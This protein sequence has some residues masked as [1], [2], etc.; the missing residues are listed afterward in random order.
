MALFKKKTTLIHHITYMGIMAA[1]NLI[2]I[3]LATH[4][5]Y[6]MVF[7]VLLL[8]FASA[9]VSYYCQKIYYLVYACATI[10]LCLI[11]NPSDTLF[12]VVP[13]VISGF[14]IGLFLEL[15]INL[16][17]P[18]LTS[19]I[20]NTAFTFA[21]VPLIDLI[22]ETSLLNILQIK[23]YK[24]CYEVLFVLV[25]GASLI[26]SILTHFIILSDSKK[27][28]IEI[29]TRITSFAPYFLGLE[30][31]VVLTFT[32]AFFYMPLAFVFLEI[33]FCFMVFLLID[34]MISKKLFVYLSTAVAVFT[35]II[36]FAVFYNKLTEPRGLI[37]FV[38]FPLLIALVSFIKNWLLKKSGNN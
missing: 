5:P 23:D 29:N 13:A 11:F 10:G 33:A 7:L 35:G 14:F 28:G 8:P 12:Y 18:I 19:T 2:F 3:L 27:I 22:G 1:I 25:F 4:L 26:Q 30:L 24:Y 38:F 31:A 36:L 21:F 17:W 32:F 9:V 34:L 6:A 16:F 37:L 15:K 20:I